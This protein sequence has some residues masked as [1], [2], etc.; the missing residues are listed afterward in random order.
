MLGNK[1]RRL[2]IYE[3][4]NLISVAL[5]IKLKA[6][7][8]IF[9]FCPHG[10]SIKEQETKNKKQVLKSIVDKLKGTA[11]EENASFIRFSPIWGKKEEN[12]RIFKELGFRT[13]PIHIHPDLT[14]E[15]NI[16][17]NDDSLLAQMRKTTRYLI[18]Q[19]QKNPD[20]KIEKSQELDDVGKFNELYQAT[21]SRHHFVPFSLDYLKK[22]FLSF[23]PDNQILILLGKY[24]EELISSAIII[25]IGNVIKNA[26]SPKPKAVVPKI[27]CNH[28]T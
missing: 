11:K 20:I 1:I 18:R 21:V 23:L 26:Q 2:G 4:N 9:L 5:I 24:K 25:I 16:I 8:G 3:N 7:R 15:L 10:P 12:I 28:G 22:E 17:P 6:K 13:A 19:A 27:G 14:W